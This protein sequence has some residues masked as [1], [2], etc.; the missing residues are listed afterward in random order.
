MKGG[1]YEKEVSLDMVVVFQMLSQILFT[2]PVTRH[3]PAERRIRVFRSVLVKCL[4]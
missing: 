4:F 2:S 3:A 1:V